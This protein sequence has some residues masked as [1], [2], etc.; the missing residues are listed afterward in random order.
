VRD[1]KGLRRVGN[2]FFAHKNKTTAI[3]KEQPKNRSKRLAALCQGY[4]I[5]CSSP[6]QWLNAARDIAVKSRIGPIP[7]TRHQRMFNRI[8]DNIIKVM[9][10]IQFRCNAMF[11]VTSLPE[12]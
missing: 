9:G 1:T 5:G 7:Y 2:V 6:I 10:I 3:A 4:G 8:D 12:S 11:P